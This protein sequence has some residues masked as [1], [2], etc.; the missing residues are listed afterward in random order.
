MT[1]QISDYAVSAGGLSPPLTEARAGYELN[2]SGDIKKNVNGSITD[3]G[4]WL[5][6]KSG[7]SGYEARF[8]VQ[9][10]TPSYGT[11]G[12]WLNLGT[13]RGFGQVDTSSAG[14][15]IQS[16]VLVE[17]RD[18]ATQTVQDSCVVSLSAYLTH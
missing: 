5:T 11:F 13:S 9:S 14:G 15:P 4:D 12:S 7:M 2:S 1:I 18:V 6:P 10:G 16:S 8:T 17:I 3:V